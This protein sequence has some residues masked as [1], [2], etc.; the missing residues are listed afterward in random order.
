MAKQVWFPISSVFPA[1]LDTE[2]DP[3]D[4]KDGMTPD[5]YGMDIDDPGFLKSGSI[6][7]GTSLIKKQYTIGA[8]TWDWYYKRAWRSSSANL[9]WNSPEY[10]AIILP[11]GL[12]KLSFDEDAQ[13][14][15]TFLPFAGNDMFVGKSTGGYRVPNASSLRGDFQHTNI[16]PSM[17]VSTATHATELDGT[18]Y[19][20][21]TNGLMAWG[22]NAVTEV[23]ENVRDSVSI[24]QSKALTLDQQ[25]KRIIGAASFVYDIATKK[26][27]NFLTSGFRFT[28]RTLR[29]SKTAVPFTVTAVGFQYVNSGT[30]DG[31]IKYQIKRDKN[32]WEDV[33][34]VDVRYDSEERTLATSYPENE[35]EARSFRLRVTSISS[36]I[37]IRSIDL[38]VDA[39]SVE[40]SWSQ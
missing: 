6:P 35:F 23:T 30:G 5:A 34:T 24:F 29:A 1:G 8:N 2:T 38:L 22:G 19:V 27:F 39:N 12:G 21:N 3:V 25:K 10:T 15:V 18:I 20:S 16:V 9:L 13:S 26:L 11:Q 40:E 17:L 37:K 32:E 31:V 7:S 4:L 36:N 14:I 33:I 28:S